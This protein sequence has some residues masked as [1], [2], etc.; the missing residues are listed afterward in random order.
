MVVRAL[1]LGGGLYGDCSFCPGLFPGRFCLARRLQSRW[2]GSLRSRR[3]REPRRAPAFL[4]A[5]TLPNACFF[6]DFRKWHQANSSDE[7]LRRQLLT[8]GGHSDSA[9]L[10]RSAT[11]SLR[12]QHGRSSIGGV[13]RDVPRDRPFPAVAVRE[14]GFLV[15]VELL[16][17]LGR[18]LDV[19]SQ[20]DGINRAGL[21]TEAAVDAFWRA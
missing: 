16:G 13:E 8:Q 18:E 12:L 14:Q 6:R 1:D 11:S 21:L 10:I 7:G 19:W 20:D 2:I 9:A 17:C 3:K 15:V 4:R 5:G